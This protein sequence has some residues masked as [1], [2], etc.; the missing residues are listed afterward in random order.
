[1]ANLEPLGFIPENIEDMGDIFKVLPPG[2]YTVVIVESD[3]KDTK[4]GGKMLEMKYQ[5]IEGQFTSETL[6]DRLNI[7]NKSDI[8]QKIGLSQLKHICDAVGHTGQLNDSEQLHGKPFSVKVVIE[9]F[10]S[11]KSDK[12]LDSNKIEK[13]MP[14]QQSQ[15]E[16]AYQQTASEQ[17]PQQ[18]LGWG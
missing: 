13:R 17:S 1:M 2:T 5:V 3:V 14:K 8:A 9:Q 10:K 15:Q 4:A 6:V 11:N 7:Q 18:S 12:M 16:T